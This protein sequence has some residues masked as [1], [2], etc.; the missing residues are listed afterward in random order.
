MTTRYRPLPEKIGERDVSPIFDGFVIGPNGREGAQGTVQD[1][2]DLREAASGS[3]GLPLSGQV[4]LLPGTYSDPRASTTGHVID[5]QIPINLPGCT[6]QPAYARY[7]PRYFGGFVIQSSD[8]TIRDIY[9]YNTDPVPGGEPTLPGSPWPGFPNDPPGGLAIDDPSRWAWGSVG[10]GVKTGANNVTVLY[11]A[12]MGGGGGFSSFSAENVRFLGCIGWG[13][14]WRGVD[15]DHGHQLYFRGFGGTVGLAQGCM[16]STQEDGRTDSGHL[17]TQGFATSVS[18][19]NTHVI[20][21]GFKGGTLLRSESDPADN[22]IW[23]DCV[24]CGIIFPNGNGALMGQPTFTDGDINFSDNLL[25]DAFHQ[26]QSLDWNTITGD[27]S[28]RILKTNP[29][30]NQTSLP[31]GENG[32][33]TDVSGGGGVDEAS[34]WQAPDN[35]DPNRVN[36]IAVDADKDGSVDIDPSLFLSPGNAWEARHF[37]N[38]TGAPDAS[39]VWTAGNI[40]LPVIDPDPVDFYMLTK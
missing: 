12:S 8:T 24:H 35:L 19:D 23:R 37:R 32:T 3:R 6:I 2:M 4:Y 9:T 11:M 15:R 29:L 36:V 38:L 20:E 17:A 30:W 25:V 1:P 27:A 16:F 5:R 22:I 28:T 31:S 33:F 34:L 13:G 18:V 26:L 40:T 14:G 10:V 21:C 7:S 39:G